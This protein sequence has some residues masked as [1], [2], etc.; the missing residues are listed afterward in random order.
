MSWQL[1]V[2]KLFLTLDKQIES[3]QHARRMATRGTMDD[4]IFVRISKADKRALDRFVEE[5]QRRRP[6]EK[7][8]RAVVMREAIWR[9][10]DGART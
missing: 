4:L 1:T 7:V 2:V 10:L 5:E 9:L 8:S 3:Q 6:R